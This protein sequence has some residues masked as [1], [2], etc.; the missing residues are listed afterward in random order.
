MP[1]LTV[2]APEG[3]HFSFEEV[4]TKGGTESMGEVPILVADTVQ[5]AVNYYGEEGVLAILDGTSLRV[6]GQNIARRL[7]A[8]GKTDDEIAK[9]QVDF[10]PGKRGGGV[11]TP[12]AR[13]KRAAGAAVEK[14][15]D[16]D[17]VAKLLEK[18]AAGEIDLAELGIE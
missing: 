13:A 6:S 7:K 15:A 14:G 1:E 16:A 12:A 8:A 10:K 5:A 4:K 3:F 17:K 11:S 2:Q 18:V 9:A